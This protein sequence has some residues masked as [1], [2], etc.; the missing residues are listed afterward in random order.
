MNPVHIL[1]VPRNKLEPPM[2]AIFAPLAL[3]PMERRERPLP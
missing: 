3:R 2:Q 1:A